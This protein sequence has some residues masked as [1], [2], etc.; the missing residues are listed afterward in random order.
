MTTGAKTMQN[1]RMAAAR[2]A[3]AANGAEHARKKSSVREFTTE[4]KKDLQRVS[5]YLPSALKVFS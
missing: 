1:D 3:K 2:A 5:D 4:E